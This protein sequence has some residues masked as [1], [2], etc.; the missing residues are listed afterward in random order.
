[1]FM[2]LCLEFIAAFSVFLP[3]L[4]QLL[5]VP[6]DSESSRVRTCCCC[7]LLRQRSVPLYCGIERATTREIPSCGGGQIQSSGLLTRR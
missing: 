4:P 2:K 6:L 5:N 7:I 3:W 1:M